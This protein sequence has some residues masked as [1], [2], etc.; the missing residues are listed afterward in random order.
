MEG[1]RKPARGRCPPAGSSL[2]RGCGSLLFFLEVHG[3][4][5]PVRCGC[6]GAGV[7][8]ALGE[9]LAEETRG[10]PLSKFRDGVRLMNFCPEDCSFAPLVGDF[11]SA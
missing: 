2:A 7:D 8:G 10:C 9:E 6:S 11:G 5:L 3:S 1:V 4:L